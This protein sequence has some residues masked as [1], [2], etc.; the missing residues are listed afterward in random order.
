MM[1]KHRKF[2]KKRRTMRKLAKKNKRRK[3]LKELAATQ[4]F[5]AE[6]KV[7][8]TNIKICR[9]KSGSV[10][11]QQ[12]LPGGKNSAPST[13]MCSSKKRI[14]LAKY[15]QLTSFD[16]KLIQRCRENGMSDG[17]IREWMEEI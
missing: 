14:S 17:E 15:R 2:D 4:Q 3:G 8:A 5:L 16:S 12:V 1:D 13:K 6:K 7:S 11:T 9:H 10:I